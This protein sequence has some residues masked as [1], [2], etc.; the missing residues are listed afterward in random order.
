[1]GVRSSGALLVDQLHAELNTATDGGGG[2]LY[3]DNQMLWPSGQPWVWPAVYDTQGH[4]H[5]PNPERSES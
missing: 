2:V 5:L 3:I 1:M 4:V